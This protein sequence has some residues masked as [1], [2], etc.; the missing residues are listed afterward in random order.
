MVLETLS[1]ML[2][3]LACTCGGLHINTT[4]QDRLGGQKGTSGVQK[5]VPKKSKRGHVGSKRG[6][7]RG[8]KADKW[9][10]KE[11]PK[12]DKWGSKEGLK[13]VQKGTSGVQEGYKMAK[14]GQDNQAVGPCLES[15]DHN[16]LDC[17]PDS[18]RNPRHTLKHSAVL[19]TALC[20]KVCFGFLA[21]INSNTR[22]FERSKHTQCFG[23]VAECSRTHTQTHTH[24]HDT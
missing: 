7:Q 8:P 10:P 20:F 24:T 3:G 16:W 1:D 2:A 5:R 14:V 12:G 11:G 9:G 18:A 4:R 13:G 23:C 6:S 15:R 21:D 19:A 22:V 17:C